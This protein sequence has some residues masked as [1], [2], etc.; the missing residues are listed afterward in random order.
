MAAKRRK[1]HNNQPKMSGLDGRGIE[2]DKRMAGGTG[3]ARFDRCGGNRVGRG[4]N[5]GKIHQF[6]KLCYFSADL[7]N[8]IKSVDAAIPHHGGATGRV[9][10]ECTGG[11]FRNRWRRDEK[12]KNKNTSLP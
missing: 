11:A 2:W 4:G 6:I 5:L 7:Q 9:A 12:Y 8:E 1:K 10:A 3:G